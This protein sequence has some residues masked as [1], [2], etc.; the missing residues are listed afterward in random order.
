MALGG[1]DRPVGG[2]GVR[3][4]AGV[5]LRPAGRADL[6]GVLALLAQREGSPPLDAPAAQ[7]RGRWE[8]VIGSVDAAPF[9]AVADGE[10]AGVLLLFFRRRLNFATWEAWVPELVVAPAFR[11]RGI[12]RALLR[13]AIEEWRLRGAHRLSVELTPGEEAGRAL[14]SGMG[15]EEAF[16]RFRQEPIAIS[17]ALR[18]NGVEIRSVGTDD[19]EA[20]TRL[21]AEMGPHRSPVPER[22]DAVR[23]SFEELIGRPQDAS[24]V[25]VQDGTV[26]GVC[27]LELREPMRSPGLE[28]WIPE[29]VVTEPMRGRGTG[30][31][32][33][34]AG[35]A[36]AVERGASSAVLES[37][38]GRRVAHALYRSF[39]FADAGAGF[40]LLRNR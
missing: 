23:R 2:L 38:N 20:V 5:E 30:G 29:L 3:A 15:L 16:V 6:D 28:A 35:L 40:I 34:A 26:V 31:A 14:L 13:V 22:M 36:Q 39:G 21:V 7:A 19:F 27:T 11:R 12:G 32:L 33:L 9:L 8:S 1:P 10:P 18:A 17:D 37:G 24:L 4:P 25:A